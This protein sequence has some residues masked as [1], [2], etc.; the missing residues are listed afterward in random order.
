MN[1]TLPVRD[2]FAYFSIIKFI[3][4]VVLF[5]FVSRFLLQKN[6]INQINKRVLFLHYNRCGNESPAH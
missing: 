4:C 5:S 1:V 2:E 3:F 6:S